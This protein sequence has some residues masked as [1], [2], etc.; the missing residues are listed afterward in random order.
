[1]I[2]KGD[3]GQW[4]PNYSSILGN[5]A[6]GGISNFYYPN[7]DRNGVGRTLETGLIGIRASAVTNVQA[8]FLTRKF[9]PSLKDKDP[10]T[11]TPRADP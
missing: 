1:M 7:T 5:L 10:N 3:N 2:C 11:P 8:E 4:Q 6:A 9:T